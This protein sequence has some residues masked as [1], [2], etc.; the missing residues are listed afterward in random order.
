MRY[1]RQAPTT[2]SGAPGSGSLTRAHPPAAAAAPAGAAPPAAGSR[3]WGGSRT[4]SALCRSAS[5]APYERSAEPYPV[6][7]VVGSVLV[8]RR[9]SLP[10]EDGSPGSLPSS[11][12]MWRSLS[13]PALLGV[14]HRPTAAGDGQGPVA[15]CSP[16]PTC[17]PHP[18]ERRRTLLR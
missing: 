9:L 2:S 11:W 12:S 8:E 18:P 15:A 6:V 14:I 7:G 5:P 13:A 16:L 4:L 17:G 1:P 3:W 10:D